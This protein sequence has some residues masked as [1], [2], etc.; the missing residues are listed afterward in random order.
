MIPSTARAGPQ[1]LLSSRTCFCSFLS[2]DKKEVGGPTIACNGLWR[3]R[4]YVI[5]SMLPPDTRVAIDYDS[6]DLA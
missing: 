5:I 1:E 2:A 6:D 3:L 4:R